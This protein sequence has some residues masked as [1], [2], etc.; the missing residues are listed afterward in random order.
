MWASIATGKPYK[1]ENNMAT[2]PL[3]TTPQHLLG[4]GGSSVSKTH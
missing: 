1:G 4:S 3:N 2:G